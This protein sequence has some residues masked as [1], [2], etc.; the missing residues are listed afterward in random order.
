MMNSA[1]SAISIADIRG[2][3]F[4]AGARHSYETSLGSPSSTT[5]IN[6]TNSV[7]D[8]AVHMHMNFLRNINTTSQSFECSITL[9]FQWFEDVSL[10]NVSKWRP[11]ISFGNAISDLKVYYRN[12]TYAKVSENKTKA[13]H[14]LLA[15]GEFAEH[16]ELR[17]F[18]IDYQRLH[19]HILLLNCPTVKQYPEY[20]DKHSVQG[21]KKWFRNKFRLMRGNVIMSKENFVEYDSWSISEEMTLIRT[22]TD[23]ILNP[24]GISF[25]K[26][27]AYVTLE[28]Q[29]QHYIWNIIFPI[30]LESLMAFSTIL[31]ER[32]DIG[33]K[34]QITLTIILTIFAVKFSCMSFLPVVNCL[35]YL[36][37]YFVS[38]IFFVCGLM[39]QNLVVF[40]LSF[41]TRDDS[42]AYDSIQTVNN[43]TGIILFS[44]WCFVQLS[45]YLLLL[46]KKIRNY[47]IPKEV[48]LG[49]DVATHEHVSEDDYGSAVAFG[50]RPI[51]EYFGKANSATTTPLSAENRN[52]AFSNPPDSRLFSP[53]VQIQ[54]N[55][56]RYK[57]P[58]ILGSSMI[59]T[60]ELRNEDSISSKKGVTFADGNTKESP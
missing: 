42:E 50:C 13:L 11:E 44:L 59:Q 39:L 53:T 48:E 18:P 43:I 32:E 20:L 52:S 10:E 19:I 56:T 4:E 30:T 16:F 7:V 54:L 24:E 55:Q 9:Q 2:G 12:T 38:S 49:D 21:L 23:P 1:L 15:K 40:R 6:T 37:L 22:K 58:F 14:V 8:L 35:T 25:C 36:D 45:T 3:V 5:T 31:V 28:R 47:V 51:S 60:P 27:I 41:Q 57:S 46:N 29:C 33:T 26:L 34:S 17:Q